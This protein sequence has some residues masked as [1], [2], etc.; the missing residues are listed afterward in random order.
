MTDGVLDTQTELVAFFKALSD[1]TRLQIAGRLAQADCTAE[2][3]AEWLG[4]KP[5]AVKHHLGLL[6]AAGLVEAASGVGGARG[7][8]YHLR[9]AGAR[10]LAGRLLSHPV[11]PVPDGVAADEFERKVLREFLTPA[12]AVRDLPVQEKK[13][14]VVLRYVLQAFEAG[15]R[16]TEKEVNARLQR[17]HPDSATLRR[18][19]I[20][21]KLM[22]RAA[23]QYR[24]VV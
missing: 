21:Y 9:L 19:M 13:L 6:L 24:R 16:Y 5:L 23:G 8:V 15:Q 7:P 4:E 3:L 10:A 2:T 14:Q 1:A 20:E 12:G 17:F 22:T 11:T 18:A